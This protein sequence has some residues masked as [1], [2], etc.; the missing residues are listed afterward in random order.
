MGQIC[1][2]VLVNLEKQ[3]EALTKMKRRVEKLRVKN[4]RSTNAKKRWMFYQTKQQW[5]IG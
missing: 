2:Y 5:Q 4:V 1:D 3:N